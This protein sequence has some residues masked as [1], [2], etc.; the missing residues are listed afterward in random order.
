[1]IN[2]TIDGLNV[3]VE[4][5]TTVLEAAKSAGINIP[6]LC[7]LKDVSNIG[8]CRVCVVEV[9]GY[10]KLPT[11]CNTLAQDGM[12]VRTQTDRVVKSRRMALDLIL[13]HHNLICFSCPSNGACELQNVCHQCGISESSYENIRVAGIEVPH[14]EDN[15]F[16]GY[17]PDLCIHCQRCINT[18]ANVSGCDSIKLTS[19]GIFRTIE[20]PFGKNWKETDCESCGNCA[21]ACPTGAIYKKEA[22]SYR[23]WEISRVRTTCP[24]CA[25]GCQYELLV[26]DNKLVGAE[27]VDGP[28]NGGRL[29]VKGRFGS[30]K[31]VMS[32]DRLTDPLI[33]DRA[34]G[35]FR[36]ASWE[37]ALD[38]VASKFM[39][40]KR[41][42]GPDSLAGFACSRSPNED[43]YMVQKMVRTCF[44]TN[45]TDN[46]ARVCHSASVEGLAKTLGSGAMT[47]PIYDIT[48]DVDA[49]LLVGSNPEEAHPVIGMQIREAVR[50]GT[51]LI[52]V[53]PRDIGLTKQADIHL[54]LRPGT[55]IAFANGMCH[56]F[57][58]EGLIDEEFIAERTEGFKELK[59]IVKDYTPER[60]AKICGIDPDD[61]RAAARIYATAKKA[62][63]IYC[64]GV[65]EHSTGTE[66][67]MSMSNMAMSVGKLGREGCGVNP[68]RGQNNVQG[69]CDMG[70]MPDKFPGYQPVTNPEIRE[71]F[72]KAWGVK[73]PAHAGTHATDIFPKAV[74]GEVKGLYI[75]GEDPVVTD[76]DTN[77]V[78]K[79]LKAL[80]FL[81][82]QELFMTETALLA[83][84]VLPGRSYAE[85]D[86]TFTNTERR[87]QRVRKAVTL[88]GN[89]R[90]DTD[91]ICELMRRM[92][93]NQ[94]TL[95]A[96]EI[97]D[98]MA[99]V[100]PSFHG[101]SYARLDNEPSQSLQWPCTD[102]YHAGTAIMHVGKMVRGLGLFYPTEY[103]PAK[104]LPDKDYPLMLM[105]G[106]ILYHYNTSAMTARTEGLMEIAGHSFVEINTE[107]AKSL[108]IAD[109]ER[110][111]IRSRRGCI[112]SEARVSDKTNPGEC[113]MPFHFADGNCNWL[114]NAALDQFARIPEY[115]VCACRIEKLPKEEAF[116]AK[117]KYISQKM[118]A[119][120]WRKR[121]DK[122]I[123]RVLG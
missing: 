41:Q 122:N 103:R 66:G 22:K 118:V 50:K 94:P 53:D 60:V 21:E 114:T 123:A 8:S 75:Y 10:D 89:A 116:N 95:T 91:I 104:E 49:I 52:V 20:T 25:V 106:R 80:D 19:R 7:Y 17:R 30:Y 90:L 9:D 44:G 15:P 108:D 48:H 82:V 102:N 2:L 34:T 120:Q 121:M 68:L 37:E 14:V 74:K 64:L 57:I 32:G 26:K 71:K 110:V 12:V 11:S 4:K 111:S 61:L 101:M 16:L 119:K 73:L 112:T 117:G 43:I 63:I 65:T 100:T 58:K 6:T 109:G 86:G 55:N 36:K 96:S 31:F 84:V 56:I 85:K 45:N 67:V 99:S 23:T 5:G 83:D 59:K 38:L 70:A 87:V 113:W 62:P 27:A 69:A 40:L 18:C 1:M 46:C 97:F 93:Y 76:P 42:Y 29:C 47:N 24:H 92:G 78:V 51:K 35:K 72:E 107:D 81:V 39:A 13:S 79:A 33:K 115:K 54:K 3:Q 77:H 105:T 98:E 88:P 28:S